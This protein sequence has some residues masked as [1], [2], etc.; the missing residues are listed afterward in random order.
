MSQF[1]KTHEFDSPDTP[2]SGKLMCQVFV[3][4]LDVARGAY[5]LPMRITSGYR[6]KAY[7]KVLQGR[8]YA[9]AS[10][11]S[12]LFGCAADIACSDET[13]IK[14]LNAF[15]FA[16]FRRFGIMNSA[17]H[18]DSDAQKPRPT[19]WS[20]SNEDTA[21]WKAAKKWFDEKLKEQNT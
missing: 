7:N 4:A 12:H 16:G 21:R 10:K 2:G 9:A 20:Y 19:M 14:M 13:L 3:Q 1:F 6:T 11:S 5:G 15:W 17:I 18:V 8:G